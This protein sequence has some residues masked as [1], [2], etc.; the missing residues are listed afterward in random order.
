MVSVSIIIPTF[1]SASHIRRCLT[2][3]C[4]QTSS[5]FELIIQDGLSK[6]KTVSIVNEFIAEYPRI[7]IRLYSQEDS[8]IYD[9]MNKALNQARGLFVYFLGSDDYLYDKNVLA[10][11]FGNNPL[12]RFDVVYG[13]A[14]FEETNSVYGGKFTYRNLLFKN[15]C[16]QSMFVKR[17]VL[18]KLGGFNTKYP[19]LADWDVNMKLF[20]GKY[21]IKYLPV[22]VAFFS[23]GGF[24][25][26]CRLDPFVPVLDELRDSYHEKFYFK[27]R[28]VARKTLEVIGLKRRANVV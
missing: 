10:T 27:L 28:K 20:S 7:D 19:G 25:Y 17:T 6:D 4:S 22:L 15:I 16:H 26:D 1:N 8:G 23:T 12:S 3:V 24:S 21:R 13:D 5:N 2:S 14:F 18:L 9:A 11:I